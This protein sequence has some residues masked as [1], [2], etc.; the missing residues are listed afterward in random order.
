MQQITSGKI[1]RQLQ[2]EGIRLTETLHRS[3][4]KLTPHDHDNPNIN[5]VIHGGLDESVE[6]SAFVCPEYSLLLKP[7]GARHSNAYGKELTHCLVIEFLPQFVDA[8][9]KKE[10]CLH[11]I[12]FARGPAFRGIVGQLRS[13]FAMQDSASPLI[14]EGLILQLLGT[15]HRQKSARET[16]FPKWL[17][18]ARELLENREDGPRSVTELAHRLQIDR[19]HLSREFLHRFG[20]TPGQYV[21]ELKLQNA[22]ELLRRTPK[23]MAQIAYDTGFSDQS[24]F[25]RAF[26]KY[27]GVTPSDY[28]RALSP[29]KRKN[30]TPVQD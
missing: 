22:V 9:A 24:H 15:L 13:E 27:M 2:I 30:H 8:T 20:V 25:T 26:A 17:K 1:A 14:L 21:R 3:G 29:Q 12:A 16:S 19:S 10:N 7:A 18:T 28:R 5:I 4:L 11:E 23:T 6:R